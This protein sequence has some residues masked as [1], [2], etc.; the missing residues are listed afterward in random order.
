[1]KSCIYFQEESN[2]IKNEIDK[3]ADLDEKEKVR[4]AIK[5]LRAPK[6]GNAPFVRR[7]HSTSNAI[8]A[9]LQNSLIINPQKKLKINCKAETPHFSHL[10]GNTLNASPTTRGTFTDQ[11]AMIV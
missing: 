10:N 3:Q 2:Y 1:M 11:E 8:R 4:K 9:P 6:D 5:S 7:T